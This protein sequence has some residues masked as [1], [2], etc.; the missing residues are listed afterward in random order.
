MAAVGEQFPV[1]G[2]VDVMAFVGVEEQ[3][4]LSAALDGLRLR[5]APT[6]EAFLNQLGTERPRVAVVG[7]PP[8]T[9]DTVEAVAALR[10]RRPTLHCILINAAEAV[11]ERLH[12]LE[13]GYD[14]ALPAGVAMAE[15]AGRATLLARAPAV[16]P[17][18]HRIPVGEGIEL[19]LARG[20]LL[21]DGR[22]VHLRPKEF[23]LLET[24]ARQPGRAF[25]RAEL[26]DRVWGLHR[27][28]NPRTVDVHIRWL[29]AKVERDP[30][31]PVHVVTVR[32]RGYRLEREVFP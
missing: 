7:A 27:V 24:L 4:R 9:L 20:C 16:H 6:S 30:D 23:H 13:L 14:A 1:L 18:R 28:G 25:S 21:R 32:G 12:A 17:Q 26:L 29:R 8:A 2:A 3:Q 5:L 11:D 31:Q 19:D 10:R 15:L 22:M